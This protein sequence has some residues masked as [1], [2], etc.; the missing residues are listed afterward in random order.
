LL[1]FCCDFCTNGNIRL[2]FVYLGCIVDAPMRPLLAHK[3]NGKDD[4]E[5]V[6]K[7]SAKAQSSSAEVVEAAE[8]NASNT[9]KKRQAGKDCRH[10]GTDEFETA[11]CLK[12]SRQEGTAVQEYKEEGQDGCS[13]K[14]P[15]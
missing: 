2:S 13:T 10:C 3:G 9:P 12:S 14:K 8:T 1:Y 5:F 7:K 4:G 6:D 15:R 11:G